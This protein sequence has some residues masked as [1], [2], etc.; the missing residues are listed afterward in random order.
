MSADSNDVPHVDHP[1]LL[2]MFYSCVWTTVSKILTNYKHAV[3]Q[4]LETAVH[5]IIHILVT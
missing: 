2:T 3:S 4:F 1:Q 5:I